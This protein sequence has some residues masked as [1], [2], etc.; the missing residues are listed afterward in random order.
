MLLTTVHRWRDYMQKKDGRVAKF[1][2]KFDGPFE[3]TTAF[4]ETSMYTLQLPD[5]SNIH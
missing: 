5:S 4:P 2:P 3:V 1:M